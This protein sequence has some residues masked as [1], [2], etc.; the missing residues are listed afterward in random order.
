[1][2]E[3]SKLRGIGHPVLQLALIALSLALTPSVKGE[4]QVAN[5]P[6]LSLQDLAAQVDTLYGAQPAAAI[7]Y[8]LEIKTRLTNA[9]SDEFR[10]IYGE[11]LFQ[12]GLAHMRWFEQSGNKETILEGVPYWEEFI[13]Q[14]LSDERYPLA[15]LN[16]AD[17][18]F[19]GEQWGPALEGYL[20]TANRYAAQ[21]KEA[22]LLGLLKRMVFAA[23]ESEQ[24]EAVKAPLWNFLRQ[25]DS[26]PLRLF[27]LNTLFDESLKEDNISDLLKLVTTINTD[28]DFRYD[29][30]VNLRL[31]HTGDKFEDEERYLEAGLLFLMVL[32]REQLLKVVEHRLIELEEWVFRNRTKENKL[33]AQLVELEALREERHKLMA[34]PKYTANL[35]WRQARVLRLME[36]NFEAYFSFLRLVNNYPQHRHIEQFSYATFVQGIKCDYLQDAMQHGEDY[37]AEPAYLLYEKPVAVQ[38]AGLYA[39]FEAVEKLSILADNFLHRF[40]FEPVAAQMSHYLGQALL[41]KGE[42]ARILEEFPL[43]VAEY[44]EGA[45]IDSANYWIGMAYLFSGN[46]ESALAAFNAL[47]ANY[48]GSVYFKEASFRRGV[49]YFGLGQYT[50][51]R[52][53]FETWLSESPGHPLVPEA[54]VFMGDL[55]AIDARVESALKHYRLV[56]THGGALSFIEHAYFESAA[57]LLANK[58]YA[59]QDQILET[60][61]N[62]YPE[63][64]ACAEAVLRLAE[65][66]LDQGLVSKAF[67]RYREG[68]E[69]FG[70]DSNSDAV[71]VV[72]DSWWKQDADIRAGVIETTAFIEALMLDESFRARMLYD[73]IAQIQYLRAHA[74]VDPQI[75]ELLTLRHPMYAALAEHTDATQALSQGRQLQ[76][77][78]YPEL[79]ALHTRSVA[80]LSKLP[81]EKP[82]Q[83]FREMHASAVQTEK[84]TL[85]LRLLRVL[86]Q[87][88]GQVVETRQFT[89]EIIEL[90]SPASRVWIAR[91]IADQD[92]DR[93][94]SILTQLVVE[95]PDSAA[96]AEG[97][98]LLGELESQ[99]KNYELAEAFYNRVLEEHFT[100][101]YALRSA[102]RR[103]DA[104]QQ[105]KQLEAAVE[106]Y[107]LVLN[108]REWRGEV[109]AEATFKIGNCFAQMDD[110]AKAQGFYERTYLAYSAYPDWSGRAVLASADLLEAMGDRESALQTYQYFLDLPASKASPYYDTIRRKR[111]TP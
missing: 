70:N 31:L 22:E 45:F 39:R 58:R 34:A 67:S 21:I 78:D 108:Q 91:L 59:D 32:P 105:N 18:L 95:V 63:S 25:N 19:A 43:W 41:K 52:E 7:P 55:D 16:R 23:R 30:G 20:F 62:K 68:V 9:M 98:F 36:R 27:C 80:R 24:I 90:A 82:A 29:I 47:L 26:Y 93:A 103:G 75:K 42:V 104:L 5:F 106:A 76:L 44:P 38:L 65:A 73:R 85:A 10:S 37:L 56:E 83:V 12:L 69:R 72:I 89:D 57:L 14:F 1:M 35:H 79:N 48:P 64:T 40:P 46:F 96:A 66:A 54:Y 60:F 74:G 50:E 17:S 13:A 81:L 6:E 84:A 11:N 8:M 51:A 33:E 71:D 100:S 101:G 77:T 49:A 107:A 86:N 87:R 109:W 111:M 61:L 53:V 97:L 88:D 28:R 99:R 4:A 92:L 2:N 110:L 3:K 15:L 102:V 94:I